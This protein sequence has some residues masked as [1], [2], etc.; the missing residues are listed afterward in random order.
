M[1][2]VLFAFRSAVA[3]WYVVPTGSMKPTIVEG[4]RIF[5]NKLAYDLKIPFTTVR[6]AQWD[7][8]QRGEVVTFKS[9]ADGTLMVKRVVGL[10]GDR[11]ELRASRLLVNGEPVAY[12]TLAEKFINVI[13][14]AQRAEH[15][16]ASESLAAHAH[17]VMHTPQ[18]QAIRSFAPFTVPAGQY[19]MMGDNRD[20]SFDSRYFGGVERGRITGRATAVVLSL[21]REHWHLPRWHRSFTALP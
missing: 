6:L 4:D 8:P 21:D 5:V 19:F 10:P 16:F 3:D 18:R 20:N 2:L 12:E 13:P 17:P 9:P 15:Q 1:A 11:I 14:A 7:D